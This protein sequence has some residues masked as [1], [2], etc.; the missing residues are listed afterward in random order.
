MAGSICARPFE[1]ELRNARDEGGAQRRRADVAED[2]LRASD[3]KYRAVDLELQQLK[4]NF[5]Q[6]KD[7]T[8][9]LVDAVAQALRSGFAPARHAAGAGAARVVH[10]AAATGAAMKRL[11]E[12]RRGY[13]QEL[14]RV[15]EEAAEARRAEAT[16]RQRAGEME[17]GPPVPAQRLSTL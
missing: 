1:R 10:E 9:G 11:E 17:V 12:E 3:E 7:E 2:A 8:R 6:C 13:D 16:A 5:R 4:E 14:R 15:G